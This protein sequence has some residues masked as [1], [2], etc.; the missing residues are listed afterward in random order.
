MGCATEEDLANP[1]ELDSE[2]QPYLIVGKGGNATDLT[3]GRYNTGLVPSALNEVGTESV[4]LGICNTGV[5][6]SDAFSAK[7]DSGSLVW[8][9]KDGKAFIAGQL[10]SGSNEDHSASNHATYYTPG[11]SLLRQIKRFEYASF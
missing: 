2:G 11:W 8:C 6:T 10:H 3:V 1:A 5:K 9:M 4:E 7:G